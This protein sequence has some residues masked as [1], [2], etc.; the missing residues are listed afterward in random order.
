MEIHIGRNNR[1]LQNDFTFQLG[2]PWGSILIFRG[3][4]KS[5][6]ELKES[7]L[8]FHG[9][10]PFDQQSPH[11]STP[12]KCNSKKP[13]LP[14][15]LATHAFSAFKSAYNSG[16]HWLSVFELAIRDHNEGPHSQH[17]QQLLN[18]CY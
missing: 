1:G 10:S 11:L 4:K 2:D 8:K 3:V 5:S 16:H 13:W 7:F 6:E 17:I 12:I 18:S 9:I 14:R 15:V